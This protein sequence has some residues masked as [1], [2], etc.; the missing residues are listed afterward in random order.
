MKQL[1]TMGVV[2]FVF[3]AT[4]L[5]ASAAS[6]LKSKK[7]QVTGP[8]L[9]LTETKIVVEKDQEKWEIAR[10]PDTK[11]TG[12]LKVGEKVTVEY[13]MVAT[14]VEVKSAKSAAAAKEVVPAATSETPPKTG[15]KNK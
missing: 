6:E 13:K 10:T 9:S 15:K 11:V 8:V 7:Y 2:A 12:D 14:D 4:V 3:G 5:S 1:L